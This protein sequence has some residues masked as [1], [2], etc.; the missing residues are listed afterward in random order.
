MKAKTKMTGAERRRLIVAA[1]TRL[2]S[3]RGFRGVTTRQLAEAVGVTEPVLYQH[4]RTKR[5]LYD[6]IIETHIREGEQ[7]GRAVC[8]RGPLAGDDRRFFLEVAKL[9]VTFMTKHPEYV[10]L[11]LYSSLE[12]HELADMSFQRHIVAFYHCL[13]DYIQQRMD[14]GAF[15][16]GDPLLAARAFVGSIHQYAI[17]DRIF[18]FRLVK[19]SR[20]R[21]IEGLVDIFL[22]GVKQT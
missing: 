16:P 21:V 14:Q 9:I 10:R 11:M 8:T 12:R 2:F 17:F 19:L 4:F 1:A 18:G 22:D 20:K 15:R 5:E 7:L 13:R 6:A 3:E